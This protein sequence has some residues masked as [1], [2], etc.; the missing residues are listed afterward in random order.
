MIEKYQQGA[1]TSSL[2]TREKMQTAGKLNLQTVLNRLWVTAVKGLRG[3][4]RVTVGTEHK[5]MESQTAL[6]REELISQGT[7]SSQYPI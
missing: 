5:T 3:N 7:I 6:S 2:A 1:T 4:G